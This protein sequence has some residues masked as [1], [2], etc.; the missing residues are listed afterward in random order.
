MIQRGVIAAYTL[1]DPKVIRAGHRARAASVLRISH[2]C[3]RACS[4]GAGAVI[5]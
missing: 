3:A 1:N 2:R 5:A 4:S